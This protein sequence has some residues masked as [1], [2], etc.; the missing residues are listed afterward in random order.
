MICCVVLTHTAAVYVHALVNYIFW[1][2]FKFLINL[3]ELYKLL[4]ELYTLLPE[5]FRIKL[6]A[7]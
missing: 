5:L 4:S 3:S 6:K 1:W 7:D 2:F